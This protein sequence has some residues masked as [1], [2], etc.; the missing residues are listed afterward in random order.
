MSI[1]APDLTVSASAVLTPNV[2]GY[3]TDAL[4]WVDLV[5]ASAFPMTA[6]FGN[7]IFPIPAW[8]S[9][10][11]SLRDGT[12]KLLP[13]IQLP[14]LTVAAA[15]SIPGTANIAT[16]HTTLYLVGET[17]ANT[18]PGP[19][20]GSPINLAIATS[21]TNTGNP[22]TTPIL[23]AEPVGDSSAGGSVS[24]TNSGVMTLGDATY[25][26]SLTLYGTD[27]ASIAFQRNDILMLN[28][29]GSFAIELNA[30]RGIQLGNNLPLQTSDNTGTAHNTLV[31]DIGNHIKMEASIAG[32]IQMLDN[33]G[34][35]IATL[36][37][38][39][40][41]LDEGTLAFLAGSISRIKYT[42]IASVT[43]VA[44]FQ[45]HNLGV[46]PDFCFLIPNDGVLTTAN[47]SAYYESSSMTSTQVKLQ[48]NSAGGIPVGLIAVK[49]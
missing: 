26:S 44:A 28:S 38:S 36:S 48:S 47:F 43:T 8:Y 40:I 18:Q 1:Q 10:P 14:K 37:A 22:A 24:L 5:N 45:N 4:N 11:V 30:A 35:A 16:L 17:P 46:A 42:H 39:G 25:N 31:Q 2:E 20:G 19:L 13:G 3:N 27:A 7:L 12:G 33:T 32:D 23:F 21:L 15:Q 49:L 6:Q 29:L 41:T 9:Y 34:S